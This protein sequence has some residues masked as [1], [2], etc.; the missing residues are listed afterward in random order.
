MGNVRRRDLTTAIRHALS[1]VA[2]FAQVLLLFTPLVELRDRHGSTHADPSAI[3]APGVAAVGADHGQAPPHNP[4]T[5]PAC[6]AQSLHA[7]LASSM[8]LPTILVTHRLVAD[9]RAAVLPQHDPPSSH[10]SRAPPVVS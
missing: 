2:I 7:Q 10:H 5:C 8:R 4:S 3:S 6:I 1:S 9:R